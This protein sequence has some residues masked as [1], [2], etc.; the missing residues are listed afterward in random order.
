MKSNCLV[1]LHDGRTMPSVGLGVFQ[2]PNTAT[3]DVV[4]AALE[5]GYRH[6]DTASF[7]RNEEG[8]GEGFRRS[9]L[10]REE[11]FITTKLWND[12]QGYDSVFRAC[13]ASLHRLGLDYLDLYL[14]HWPAPQ[15][16]L[17]VESWRAF[18]QLRE[19]GLVR[20]IGV[21]NFEPEHL[22]RI[23]EEVGVIPVVNQVELH[24][25]FQQHSLRKAH[26]KW[27]I[28]TESWSPLGQGHLLSHPLIT[29]IA[30]KHGRTPAQIIIRWHLQNDLVVIPKSQSP[31]RV[32]SN[33]DVFDFALDAND[34]AQLEDLDSA[35]ARIG[36]DPK[37][38][39]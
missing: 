23:I 4:A 2:I 9:G 21:S 39:A 35:S 10:P 15:C 37:T 38:F 33:Y 28:I 6:I 18:V 11:V 16:D 31:Q 14:I 32:A 24:T 34:M 20:S 3:S 19:Q 27:G 30:A 13:E 12:E 1:K 29:R 22:Q 5:T 7:Y 26:T 25:D 17:Y 8:V 36:P